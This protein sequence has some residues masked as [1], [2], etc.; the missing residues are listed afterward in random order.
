LK[1]IQRIFAGVNKSYLFKSYVISFI[2]GGFF[3]YSGSFSDIV[4]VVWVIISTILF[5]FAT[6]VWDDFI[7]TMMNGYSFSFSIIL[8]IIW[9]IAKVFILY[10]F[11][12]LIAPIGIIYILIATRKNFILNSE[13]DYYHKQQTI[14][15][16]KNS[17]FINNNSAINYGHQEIISNSHN[18]N[19]NN[20]SSINISGD[21]NSYQTNIGENSELKSVN[22]FENIDFNWSMI[23]KNLK[24]IIEDN[25]SSPEI[26]EMAKEGIKYTDKKDKKGFIEFVKQHKSELTSDFLIGISSG[27]FIDFIKSILS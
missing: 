11:A 26:K 23:Y 20:N 10:I 5:P 12:I 2:I 1:L 19:G 15:N 8:M 21:N 3:L 9:K 16:S 6:I 27:F 17:N 13:N 7:N 18:N 22:N 14:I 4:G 25:E 24:N